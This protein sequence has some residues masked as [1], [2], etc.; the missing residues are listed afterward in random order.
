[1]VR[2]AD[3]VSISEHHERLRDH[4]DQVKRTDRPL[5]LTDDGQAEAVVLSLK[6]YDELQ[7]EA[8]LARSLAMI[9][10]SMSGVQAGRTRAAK[11]AIR[12]IA[13]ELGLS[14]WVVSERV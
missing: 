3:S 10:Q 1:M 6:A 8:E 14:P 7:D 9:D 2:Q 12:E 5:Y 4:L 11:D 13:D